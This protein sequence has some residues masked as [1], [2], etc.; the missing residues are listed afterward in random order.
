MRECGQGHAGLST[1]SSLMDMPKPI[2]AKN[3]DKIV[4]KLTAA[5]KTVAEDTMSDAC[6]ELKALHQCEN[7]DEILDTAVSCDGTWQRRGYSS[8]NGVVSV[9]SVKTGKILDIETMNKVCKACFVLERMGFIHG[10]YLLEGCCR[11]NQK[12]LYIFIE[13]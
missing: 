12:R 2:T 13:L 4:V 7:P 9:I 11:I 5:V 6:Q 1:F 8:N 3:Y 10:K